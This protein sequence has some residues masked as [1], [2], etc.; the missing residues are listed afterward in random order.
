MDWFDLPI[1]VNSPERESPVQNSQRVAAALGYS[2]DR[3]N[4]YC[5]NTDSLTKPDN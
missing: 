5:H 4:Y 3:V 1:G 2:Y